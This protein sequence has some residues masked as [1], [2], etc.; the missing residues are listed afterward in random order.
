MEAVQVMFCLASISYRVGTRERIDC[1]LKQLKI[2]IKISSS[3]LVFFCVTV[4]LF[5]LVFLVKGLL[6][7]I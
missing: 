7:Q 1:N 2:G 3:Q 6:E 4:F 5:L